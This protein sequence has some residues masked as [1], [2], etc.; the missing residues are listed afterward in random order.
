[1]LNSFVEKL[2]RMHALWRAKLVLN[3]MPEHLKEAFSQKIA[4]F[5]ALNGKRQEWGYSRRWKADYLA[6]VSPR[7]IAGDEKL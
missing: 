5:Y 7:C 4:A 6:L 2:K 1:V 3:K